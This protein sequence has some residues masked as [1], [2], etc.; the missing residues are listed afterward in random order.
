MYI[1]ILN[2]MNLPILKPLVLND[3]AM[4]FGFQKYIVM[5]ENIIY[6]FESEFTKREK[7]CIC[8]VNYLTYTFK[9]Y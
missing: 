2:V 8:G 3:L 7:S 9:I 6:F 4:L 1:D 5:N